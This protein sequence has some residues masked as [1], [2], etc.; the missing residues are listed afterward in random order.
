MSTIINLYATA[1]TLRPR[2]QRYSPESRELAFGSQS[3]KKHIYN[4][5][6]AGTV[7]T[8]NDNKRSSCGSRFSCRRSHSAERDCVCVV[9]M[10]SHDQKTT[11]E[12][13]QEEH[14][15]TNN[16]FDEL[17]KQNWQQPSKQPIDISL[18]HSH[19]SNSNI[20][21]S[22]PNQTWRSFA[23]LCTLFRPDEQ[24][25]FVI[26]RGTQKDDDGHVI[27]TEPELVWKERVQA[28]R[29]KFAP[30]KMLAPKHNNGNRVSEKVKWLDFRNLTFLQDDSQ[31]VRGLDASF[32]KDFD[33]SPVYKEENFPGWLHIVSDSKG[34]LEDFIRLQEFSML[35]GT[36]ARIGFIWEIHTDFYESGLFDRLLPPPSEQVQELPG[37]EDKMLPELQTYYHFHPE[38]AHAHKRRCTYT[39]N[40]PMQLQPTSMALLRE[41]L[42]ERV[43]MNG[44][45]NSIYGFLHI[46]RGD[47]I[48]EC[49]TRIEVIDY[50]LKCYLN[51]TET[52]GKNITLLLGS[53]EMNTTY[54]E[55]VRPAQKKCTGTEFKIE[56]SR[57]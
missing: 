48:A 29:E 56:A 53:D 22:E 45:T 7:H 51:G 27:F 57:C 23:R 6:T 9:L 55:K 40:N 50:F 1:T 32:S 14:G 15:S 26:P 54:R 13:D 37:Y 3:A 52:Q 41:A 5:H 17:I 4:N 47:A 30:S 49:D 44:L 11:T 25:A 35:Q 19:S 2:Q 12:Q 20:N 28:W 36:D 24:L 42:R 16:A 38:E 34:L 18:L 10:S 33:A 21:M 39:N 31:A 43:R 46:R 8:S